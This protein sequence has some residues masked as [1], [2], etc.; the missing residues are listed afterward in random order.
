MW[1]SR[2]SSKNWFLTL[3]LSSA[4]FFEG[5]GPR[6][7]GVGPVVSSGGNFHPRP[8]FKYFWFEQCS[9]PLL[10]DDY[11]MFFHPT[12]WVVSQSIARNPI[13]QAVYNRM[14]WTLIIWFCRSLI[15]ICAN[16]DILLPAMSLSW[17][18]IKV[19]FPQQDSKATCLWPPWPWRVLPQFSRTH[20]TT[21]K[22]KLPR[23]GST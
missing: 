4:E 1:I 22:I 9:K 18:V 19:F 23:P 15:L 17:L 8:P 11:W 2:W 13:D 12:H 16:L 20:T 14:F 7:P 6:V 21:T 10:L 3:N 5:I